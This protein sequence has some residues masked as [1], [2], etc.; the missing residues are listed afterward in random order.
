MEI[1]A[2]F[3][4]PHFNENAYANI[5]GYWTPNVAPAKRSDSQGVYPCDTEKEAIDLG[6]QLVRDGLAIA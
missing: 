3:V 6:E 2:R 4:E 1:T 5:P